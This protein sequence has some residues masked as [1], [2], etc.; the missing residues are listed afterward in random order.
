MRTEEVE[1]AELGKVL[2]EVDHRLLHRRVVP[3][4]VRLPERSRVVG[5]ELLVER[6][7]VGREPLERH[8]VNRTER[9]GPTARRP[10]RD[11][12]A[13]R[14]RKKFTRTVLYPRRMADLLLGGAIDPASHERI[15][16]DGGRQPHPRHRRVHHPWRDRRDDRVGQDGTR[17]RADRGGAARRRTRCIAIDPKGDLTNLRLMFPDLAPADFRPWI[18]EAQ[19]KNAGQT[20][21][22]F[23]AAQAA[24]WSEGLGKW[25]VD[26][27]RHRR[28]ASTPP[29][30]RSTRRAPRRA[31]PSNLVGSLQV[32]ADMTDAETVADEIDGYVSG[33]LGLV[34]IEADPCRA[35]STSCCPT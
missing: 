24:L 28:A 33:L 16:H 25:G 3:R 31:C 17:R 12:V 22:D 32:P 26:R 10:S 35:A 14:G 15:D 20:P 11:R 2:G 34:G 4:L 6:D 30:S 21:D 23:A 29:T 18:D 8:A 13:H 19:A 9:F 1:R 5:L 7:A 27:R